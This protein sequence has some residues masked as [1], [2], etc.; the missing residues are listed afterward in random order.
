MT[1]QPCYSAPLRPKS[2]RDN[3]L[4]RRTEKNSAFP[5]LGQAAF[6][7]LA[8]FLLEYVAM[9]ALSDALGLRADEMADVWGI[10]AVLANAVMF[11]LLMYHKQLTYRD[12]FHSSRSSV[13]ATVA[14]LFVPIA[15]LVP[16]LILGVM[17]LNSALVAILPL[18][19]SQQLMFQR[20]MSGSPMSVM[21]ICVLAPVLE[22]MLF[23]GIIFRSFLTQY[24][25]TLS[26][27]S[28]AAVFG[29]AHLNIY[30]FF[31]G[32]LVGSVLA[33]L[34]ERSRSL[35]PCIALHCMYNSAAM[36]FWQAYSGAKTNYANDFSLPVWMGAFALAFLGAS[37]LRAILSGSVSLAK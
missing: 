37:A 5:S 21:T 34:Y 25:R 10:A 6:I 26:I 22:E 20:M 35:W 15:L 12:L 7:V 33:W 17:S 23:R 28:S 3:K 19:N 31:V 9:A 32:L 14:L 27:V 11:S 36:F 1:I 8:L 24:S 16:A 29:A 13:G 2:S 4:N 30:Q 18:S